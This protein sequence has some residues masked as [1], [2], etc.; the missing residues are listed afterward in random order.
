MLLNLLINAEQALLTVEPPPPRTITVRTSADERDVR[1]EIADSGPGVPPEIRDRIF[2]PFF[3]TKPEG[4]GTGLGLS[5]CYGIAQD[6]GGRISVDSEPERGARFTVV[7]PR[8]PRQEARPGEPATAPA[9]ATGR[10]TVLV[11]DDEI[12]LRSAML[13]F[14]E[15]RGMDGEGVGDGREALRRLR[16]RSFDVIISDVRMPGMS[17]PELLASLNRDW[18]NLTSRLVLS[19]GDTFAPDTA[20]LL[21]GAGVPVVTKPFDFAVLERGIREVAAPASRPRSGRCSRPTRSVAVAC[22]RRTRGRP[23]CGAPR[24][25]RRAP[26]WAPDSR[27]FRRRR[28][29]CAPRPAT[30]ARHPRS[31]CDRRSTGTSPA[32]SADRCGPDAGPAP[33]DSRACATA[34]RRAGHSGRTPA[35]TAARG[36][37]RKRWCRPQWPGGSIAARRPCTPRGRSAGTAR[38]AAAARAR[39]RRTSSRPRAAGTEVPAP[40]PRAKRGLRRCGAPS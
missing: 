16:E 12:A 11:V 4:V 1:L 13:R 27:S 2:D 7:L 35:A 37:R 9:A 39:P 32:C 8:D 17:G 21:Q 3:T 22:C 14:L 33:T 23:A 30:P 6:H 31:G 24:S 29:P 5:M 18:P 25:G 38:R 15:R 19:T 10:L 20:A 36:T 26:R 40:D 28:S 34:A